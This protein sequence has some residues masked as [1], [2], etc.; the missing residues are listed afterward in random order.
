MYVLM[1]QKYLTNSFSVSLCRCGCIP[2]EAVLTEDAVWGVCS[3][4]AESTGVVLEL[5]AE[6]LAGE[7][8]AALHCAEG[9]IHLLGNLVVFISCE[10]EAERLAVFLRESVYGHRYFLHGKRSFGSSES[11]VLTYIKVVEILGLVNDGGFS[12]GL[13]IIVDKDIT[14]YREDPSLEIDV[15]DVFVFVVERFE[16]SVLKEVFGSLAVCGQLIGEAEEVALKTDE[17]LFEGFFSFHVLGIFV[18][19]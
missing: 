12:D 10:I 6:L 7:E 16:G 15:V 4:S 13:T 1:K 19:F 8:D 11:A 2:E 18:V 3:D 14:H 9:K 17:T 5:L